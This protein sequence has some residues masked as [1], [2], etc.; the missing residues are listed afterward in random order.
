[1]A[2]S[3]TR[4]E[5]P[6]RLARERESGLATTSALRDREASRDQLQLCEKVL[7]SLTVLVV[8][9]P[10]ERVENIASVGNVSNPCGVRLGITGNTDDGASRLGLIQVSLEIG[11]PHCVG[12]RS[13]GQEDHPI[14]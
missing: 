2:R 3:T 1:M 10:A 5:E 8:G 4:S 6:H 11:E 12:I 9:K 7:G 13:V 14:S